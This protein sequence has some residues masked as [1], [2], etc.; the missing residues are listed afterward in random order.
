MA[1]ARA[2]GADN[3]INMQRENLV[4]RVQ[5]ETAGRLAD[6][7]LDLTPEA[8]QPVLDAIEI[9]RPGG[10]IVLA[11]SKGGRTFALPTDKLMWKDVTLRGVV[12]V[13]HREYRQAID[14]IASGRYPLHRLVTHRFPL[15]DTKAA[16]RTLAGESPG[17]EPMCIAIEPWRDERVR[18]KEHVT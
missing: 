12:G 14:L 17:E 11:G 8:T 9:D 13:G 16:I 4:E 3:T 1:L 7:V 15:R 18:L 2:L 10:T 6:V 5:E